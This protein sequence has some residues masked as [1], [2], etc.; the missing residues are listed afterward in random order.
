[1]DALDNLLKF[2]IPILDPS[3]HSSKKVNIYSKIN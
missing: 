1:M 2:K 3:K